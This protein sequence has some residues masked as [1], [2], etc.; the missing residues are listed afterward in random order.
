[1][2][3]AQIARGLP[4]IAALS[5]TNLPKITPP[6]AAEYI[7]AADNDVAGL[8]GARA[9]ASKLARVGPLVRLAIP[10]RPGSDWN[11]VL[12]EERDG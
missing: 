5:A 7:V 9:L 8:A 11:D 6:R 12:M 4:A 1:M 10:P 2:A 3:A